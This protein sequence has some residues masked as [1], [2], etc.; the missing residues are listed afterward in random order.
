[1]DISWALL[2][3]S[4]FKQSKSSNPKQAD[5]VQRRGRKRARQGEEALI[6]EDY[7]K[8]P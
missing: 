7:E 4:R 8:E 2:I 3:F 1:L 6:L 5:P